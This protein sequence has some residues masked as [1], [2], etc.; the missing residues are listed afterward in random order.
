MTSSIS[1]VERAKAVIGEAGLAFP[2]IPGD[3]EGQLREVSEWCFSTRLFRLSPYAL[4]R[5]VEEARAGVVAEY[6]LLAHD[7][8][9]I[10][11]YAI[12]YYLVWRSLNLFLQLPWGGVYD[13]SKAN[14][15]DIRKCFGI[16]DR[17]VRRVERGAQTSA[18]LTVVGSGFY[19]SSW[20]VEDG[21]PSSECD[22]ASSV[23]PIEVLTE[24]L[25]WV[26]QQASNSS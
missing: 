11:S 22:S 7:G 4:H 5:Y 12:H 25:A 18:T 14:K 6:A 19:G 10:N 16:A 9:G 24:A 2:T 3:L 15:A 1:G 23:P 8:H 21:R 20:S 13:D 26:D 17:L